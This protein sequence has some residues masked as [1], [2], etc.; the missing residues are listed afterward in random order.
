MYFMFYNSKRFYQALRYKTSNEVYQTGIGGGV[1]IVDH[2]SD[3]RVS[4][5]EKV[6]QRQSAVTE[7]ILS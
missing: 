1:T 3:K 4:L 7:S 5:K 6:G 2:F